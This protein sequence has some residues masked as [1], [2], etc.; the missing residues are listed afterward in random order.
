[1]NTKPILSWPGGKSRLLKH[2]VP[3]IPAAAGYIEVFA[4]GCA[5]LLAKPPSKLE[6]V[7]D[8]NSDLVTLYRVA[9][10]HPDALVAELQL[11]PGSRQ[12]LAECVAL[13]KAG[14]LTDLQR[15]SMFLHANKT[16]FCAS[17]DSYAVA[18][19]PGS[20]VFANRDALYDRIRM[21]AHRMGQVSIEHMDYRR[22]LQTYDHPTC[23]SSIL[24]TSGRTS[25]TT[26][27]GPKSKW[28]SSRQP[29]SRCQAVGL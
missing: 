4:G 24:P 27:A 6:V 29:S 1:M 19:N 17:G 10:Y 7:N 26:A 25:R 15:A 11:M 13:M 18:K 12:Y 9:K 21:F 23:S 8:I 3:H 2:I 16:S 28:A 5:V 14:G 20:A 22:L